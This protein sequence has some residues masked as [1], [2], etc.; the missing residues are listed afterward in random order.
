MNKSENPGTQAAASEDELIKINDSN[1]FDDIDSEPE[2]IDPIE[3]LGRYF[4]E[5]AEKKSAQAAQE[6]KMRY[7]LVH[8]LAFCI[9]FCLMLIAYYT[10]KIFPFGDR[11]IMVVDSWHQYYPFLQELQ[12]KLTNGGS[13][14][15]SWN[16]GA[17]TNFLALMAYYASTPI[18]LFSVFCPEK[19][20]REFMMFATVAKIACS[21]L[22]FSIYLRGLFGRDSKEKSAISKYSPLNNGLAIIGFS[23][24]YAVSA[25]AV[26][27]YWCIMWLDCMALLPLVVLGLERLIDSGKYKLYIIALG[28]T[29]ICNYYIAIFVCEFIAVYYVVLYFSRTKRPSVWGFVTKT[30]EAVGA[31]VVGVGLSMFLL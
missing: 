3:P 9:P 21:G 1:S 14:L 2:P 17:G 28:V 24:L 12:H 26:G 29:V 16:T 25:Y 31:S 8:I 18:Y 6:R 13:L 22:F 15:Y 7:L 19:Y 5:K 10:I 30:A 20:L 11:Q 27:Y 4:I 23:V